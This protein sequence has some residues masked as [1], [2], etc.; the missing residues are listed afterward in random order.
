[1]E[2]GG[3]G[4]GSPACLKSRSK[5]RYLR[6]SSETASALK[7][8]RHLAGEREVTVTNASVNSED[9]FPCAVIKV[10]GYDSS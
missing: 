8:D 4:T 3:I 1:M 5:P 7:I 2:C 9:V 10:G 6:P